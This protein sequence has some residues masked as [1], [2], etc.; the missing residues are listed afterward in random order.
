MDGDRIVAVDAINKAR[1]FMLSKKLIAQG[2]R[3]EPEILA[4]TN[5][6][7]K[8]LANAALA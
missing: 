6:N 5:L 2:C 7:F 8:E 3:I 1:E 4:D